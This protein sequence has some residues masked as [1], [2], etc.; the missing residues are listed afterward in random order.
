ML[1]NYINVDG[2]PSL[3]ICDAAVGGPISERISRDDKYVRIPDLFM[4]LYDLEV[5]LVS[6]VSHKGR[7]RDHYCKSVVSTQ[8]D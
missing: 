6:T 7:R 2:S 1:R 5:S 8:R 4:N 3:W